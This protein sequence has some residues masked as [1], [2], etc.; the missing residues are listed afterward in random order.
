MM[1]T[2]RNREKKLIEW[3]FRF[4]VDHIEKGRILTSKCAESLLLS[5]TAWAEKRDYGI[6]GGFHE[7]KSSQE[8]SQ[9]EFSFGLCATRD[10]QLIPESKAEELWE[11]ITEFC[12]KNNWKLQGE[13]REFTQEEKTWPEEL[14][15]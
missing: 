15:D 11:F 3:A 12:E 10:H 14:L 5:M 2:K 6:G 1:T 8:K 9:W 7:M 13:F 4:N